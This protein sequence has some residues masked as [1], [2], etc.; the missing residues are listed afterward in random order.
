MAFAA[1]ALAL[2]AIGIYGVISYSVARR[3]PE[4]GVRMALGASRRRIRASVVRDT[5]RLALTGAVFASPRRSRCRR[6]WRRYWLGVTP[7]D[8]ISSRSSDGRAPLLA[9]E[10]LLLSRSTPHARRVRRRSTMATTGP[11]IRVAVLVMLMSGAAPL[12]AQ[13]AIK[14]PKN[15][16]TPT[17]GRR[18]RPR[19]RGRS[20]AAVSDHRGRAD[21]PLSRPSSAIDSSRRRR[22]SSRSRSTSIRSRR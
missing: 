6:C 20:P 22:R 8:P 9:K 12:C 13:T 10:H 4:I 17:A 16:Y 11:P 19:S 7:G 2:A 21:R 18:A 5:L 15:R 14:L 1:A 3:T